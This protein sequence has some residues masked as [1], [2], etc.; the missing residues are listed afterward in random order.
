MKRTYLIAGGV[1]V[2][3]VLIV[4]LVPGLGATIEGL[5]L[6]FLAGRL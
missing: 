5:L 6:R 2:A 1:L 4:L 3:V